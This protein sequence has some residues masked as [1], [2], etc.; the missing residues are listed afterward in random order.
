MSDMTTIARPYA[1]AIFDHAQNKSQLSLWS[2][3]L[4]V[5]AETVHDDLAMAF[6]SNPSVNGED[7]T[8][9]LMSVCQSEAFKGEQQ[10]IASFLNLLADN[11]RLLTLPDIYVQ[12]HAL[13]ESEEKN[14]SVQVYSFS[15]LSDK[16]KQH[17]IKALS[18]RLNKTISI[19]ESVDKSLLG[20]A[21]I[22]AGD[23]V[24]DGSV[25]GK[26]NQLSTR[27]ATSN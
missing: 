1:K 8:S 13:R 14:I 21:I 3:I 12:F 27:L 24:I 5:L 7:Q 17:L 22:Q 20:G 25:R 9:L 16:Q 2:S 4:H 11:K 10:A 18:E 19:D 6:I 15:P 23:L 26:L